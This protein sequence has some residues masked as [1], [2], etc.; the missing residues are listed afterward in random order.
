MQD[1]LNHQ[2]ECHNK[3]DINKYV[4][5]VESNLILIE[6]V[7]LRTQ[8]AISATKWTLWLHVLHKVCL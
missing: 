7:Q 8:P 5:T 3:G 1:Q 6:P 2:A 4:L